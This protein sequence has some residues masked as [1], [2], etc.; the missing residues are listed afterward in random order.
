MVIASTLLSPKKKTISP[1][2]SESVS[3]LALTGI[4][5]KVR[6]TCTESEARLNPRGQNLPAHRQFVCTLAQW[7]YAMWHLAQQGTMLIR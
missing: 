7:D 6:H 1:L 3:F 5:A 2:N 4:A